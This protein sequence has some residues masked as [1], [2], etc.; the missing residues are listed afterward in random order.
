MNKEKKLLTNIF[1]VSRKKLRRNFR[2]FV[3]LRGKNK[4]TE[5]KNEAI[6]LHIN[7]D[8]HFVT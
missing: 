7:N 5:Q 3:K 2:L 1:Q 4:E 6:I 8:F